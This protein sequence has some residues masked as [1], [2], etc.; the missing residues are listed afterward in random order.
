MNYQYGLGVPLIAVRK[1]D[2]N[3]EGAERFYPPEMAFPL[4]AFVT[5]P[6]K[7][8]DAGRGDEPRELTLELID[9]LRTRTVGDAADADR[10]R[11][12]HAAGLH[13]V[14]V[15]P[16]TATDGPACSAPGPPPAG[17]A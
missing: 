12:D 15:R 9:P 10:E 4:T 6:S 16:R 7:L 8:R 14:E 1:S 3:A 5:P 2:K 11:P 17:R 13:V